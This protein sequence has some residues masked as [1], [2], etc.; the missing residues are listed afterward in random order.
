MMIG[1][2]HDERVLADSIKRFLEKG[3]GYDEREMAQIWECHHF[4]SEITSKQTA[5]IIK[6]VRK[7][8]TET[9]PEV[10]GQRT[11]DRGQM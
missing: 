4:I 11:E 6:E 3:K 1:N 7:A 2:W 8:L 9:T 5:G 10:G